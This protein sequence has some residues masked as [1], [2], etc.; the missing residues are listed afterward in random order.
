ALALAAPAARGQQPAATAAT[1]IA[2]AI[3]AQ[4]LAAA[5]QA[6]ATQANLTLLAAPELLAGKAAP[7][8]Q[9]TLAPLD[10]AQRLLAGSGLEARLSGHTLT[11]ARAAVP[12]TTLGEVTVTGQQDAREETYDTAASVAVI[13]RDDIDRLQARNTS[14]LFAETAGVNVAVDRTSPG[15]AVNIRGLQ[16]FGRVNM[17]VDGARQNF[18]QV[19]G[20]SNT[21]RAYV[22]ADLLGGVDIDKGLSSTAGGA[23]VLAGSVN[24]RT[25]EVGDLVDKDGKIGGRVNATT[26]SNGYNFQGSAAVGY[27]ASE[28]LGFVAAVSRKKVGEYDPGT[29]GDPYVPATYAS[30][31]TDGAIEY[32]DQD[33]TSALLK[34][35]LKLSSTQRL[36]LGYVA[37]QAEYAEDTSRDKL[38]N[39]TLNASYEWKPGSRWIDLKATAYAVRTTSA[40]DRS[41]TSASSSQGI[42]NQTIRTTTLGATLENTARLQAWGQDFEWVQGGE[43]FRDRT[44]S[45][46][47]TNG[48]N[49][50]SYLLDGD[51]STW[52]TLSNP[53]GIRTVASVFNQLSWFHQD[54]LQ[55]S[56]GLRYDRYYLQGAGDVYLGTVAYG[57]DSTQGWS[58]VD[59]DRHGGRLQPKLSLA[60]T[61]TDWL[62][63]F[64]SVGLGY[65]PPA[66]TETLLS[67]LHSGSNAIPYLPNPNLKPETSRNYEIGVN[68]KRDGWLLSGDKARLKAAL[69]RNDVS[70]YIMIADVVNPS[71]A[72]TNISN[73][74]YVNLDG[75]AVF[76]GFEL[77]ADYDASRWFAQF[78]YTR[79]LSD[80]GEGTY[81]RCPLGCS[82][83]T[84][85]TASGISFFS[86]TPENKFALSG[87]VRLFER[88]LTLGARW[89]YNSGTPNVFNNKTLQLRTG[90]WSGYHLIDLWASYQATRNLTL[91]ATVQNLRD[92]LYYDALSGTD[93][94]RGPGR[95]YLVS[96]N[97]KF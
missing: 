36:K 80:L 91:R 31:V 71:S 92:Q 29:R 72:L 61:P 96:V 94:Y 84:Q 6:L 4:P 52:T 76:K 51:A 3:P 7:A 83:S 93:F 37:Y 63:P 50:S 81:N 82:V 1:A 65:R 5:L 18:R 56:G 16:D 20:H 8:V 85:G 25:L 23:G 22:D 32:T 89:T 86:I 35:D 49:A 38:T 57:D 44:H 28:D 42:D 58:H 11:I 87:G 62:Q 88:K 70:N 13:T 79:T 95:T 2:V 67:G 69:F 26:G 17:M 90:A 27:R 14:D 77:Q 59:V 34:A 46:A 9:G 75:T 40:R 12:S 97:W 55:L 10:A 21:S 15:V 60:L 41:G 30:T 66:I 39:H 19:V 45:A 73:M 54:W 24:F 53:A 33:Q 78:S 47:S 48:S 64:A 43:I 68:L 74:G